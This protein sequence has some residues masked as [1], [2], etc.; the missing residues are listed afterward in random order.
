MSP[1]KLAFQP[2]M[3][4]KPPFTVDAPGYE[5]VEG[6][7]IPRRHPAV[8]EKLVT[9]PDVNV[10]TLFDIL[11]RTSEKYGNAK[12]VGC[13]TLIKTHHE[14]KKIKKMVNG[15]QQEV[16]KDWTFHELSGYSYIS[17]IEFERLALQVGAGLRKLGLEKG[18]R[19]HVFAS[20]SIQWLAMAHGGASQTIP[21]VTSYDSLGEEGLRHSMMQ[22]N[23]KAVFL[24]PALLPKLVNP[25]KEAT[26]IQHVIY[27]H[28]TE[29]K[30]EHID[31]LRQAH[32]RLNI[33]SF[34]EF[35]KLGE[36]NPVVPVPPQPEDLCCI[37]YTSGSTGT[38]KGVPLKH[39]NVVAAVAG[40]DVI[41][42]RYL[43]PGDSMLTYLP[44]AHILEFV[45][46]NVCLWW[47]ATMG[48][49]NPKTLSDASVRNCKGDIRECRPTLLVGVPAVWETVKKGII[50]KVN[51]GSPIVK[52]MFWGAMA[53]KG[54]LLWAGLPGAAVLDSVVFK[55]LKEATGGR[56]RV[57]MNGGGPIAKDTQR[58]ISMAIAPMVNGYGLTETSAMGALTDP[59]EWNDEAIGGLTGCV[60]VKLVD[61]AEAGYFTKNNPPQG[62][63]WIRGDSVMEGYYKNEEETKNTLTADGWFMT[64]DVGEWDRNGHL[65]IIDR[66]KNLVKTLNGEY[67]ALEKLESIYR[68]AAVV[69]NICVYAAEDKARPV[70]II[71]PA[72]PALKKLAQEHG[73]QGEGLEDLAHDEKLQGIVTKELQSVG[74]RSGLGAIEIIDGVV[75]DDEE[76]TPQNNLVTA[77][78]K[79]NRRGILQR[80]RKGVD[81]VYARSS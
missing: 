51:S 4:K 63:V 14:S 55:K 64:G 58:F 23:A 5:P 52:N 26:D 41:F 1:S 56:L 17:Y 25:L 33:L 30:Q 20:S 62:E 36:D 53:A 77:V 66:R 8:A 73:V 81:K 71:F 72:E 16:T 29:V 11:K 38:P 43:G 18:D 39:K 10:A 57:T 45:F 7:T 2:Q 49:G 15:E 48:Y 19:A 44:L 74:R 40:V 28:T 78:Q 24:D 35:R 68:S 70:A 37:M 12:A 32:P 80:N 61:Y 54:F 31:R 42:G 69:A 13:R 22:T 3:V 34:E 6:E 79:L 76:W 27:N 59:L 50:A 46:E 67:I 75:M 21:I 47:G 60:D 9:R 65:K